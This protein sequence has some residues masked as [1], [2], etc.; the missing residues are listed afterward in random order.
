MRQPL[1][2]QRTI[3]RGPPSRQQ[4]LTWKSNLPRELTVPCLAHMDSTLYITVGY[5]SLRRPGDQESR[6]PQQRPLR[7]INTALQPFIPGPRRILLRLFSTN[8]RG[9]CLISGMMGPSS[10]SDLLSGQGTKALGSLR[11]VGAASKD[12]HAPDQGLKAY[13]RGF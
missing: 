3:A 5:A 11:S 7:G 6:A 13:T 9:R 2:P 1:G 4:P 8:T 10:R 12:T